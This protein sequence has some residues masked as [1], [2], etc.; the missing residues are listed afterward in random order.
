M[1][2]RAA[3][4]RVYSLLLA[5]AWILSPSSSLLS[6]PVAQNHPLTLHITLSELIQDGS[7]GVGGGE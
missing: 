7:L 3:T 5:M 1:L 6:S 2:L 4:S